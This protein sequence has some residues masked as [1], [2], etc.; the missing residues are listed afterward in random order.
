MKYVVSFDSAPEVYEAA[1]ALWDSKF[2]VGYD[3]FCF[4]EM[5]DDVSIFDNINDAISYAYEVLPE[6]CFEELYII[7]VN[8][9]E[10]IKCVYTINKED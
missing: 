1:F 5:V 2:D 8:E 6:V 4:D 7:E 10:E 3:W 9:D